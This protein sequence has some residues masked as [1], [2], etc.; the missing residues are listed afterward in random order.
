M[1]ELDGATIESQAALG[2]LVVT[3]G[4][5]VG[6]GSNAYAG[7]PNDEVRFIAPPGWSWPEQPGTGT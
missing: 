1:V 4:L 5:C 6:L 7:R 2:A 3:R